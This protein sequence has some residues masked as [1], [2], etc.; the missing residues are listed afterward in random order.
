MNAALHRRPP[1]ILLFSTVLLCLR[2]SPAPSDDISVTIERGADEGQRALIAYDEA[3]QRLSTFVLRADGTR[4]LYQLGLWQQGQPGHLR[5]TWE[6]ATQ[7]LD[8]QITSNGSTEAWQILADQ[9]TPPAGEH[10]RR[11]APFRPSMLL[12]L[13]A[14]AD[15][16]NAAYLNDD[17]AA[18]CQTLAP[19]TAGMTRPTCR[20]LPASGILVCEGASPNLC[21]GDPQHTPA[22]LRCF[23]TEEGCGPQHCTTCCQPT[24]GCQKSCWGGCS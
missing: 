21:A 11:L 15:P 8:L 18:A 12:W 4:T 2:C 1:I 13:S 9:A 10:E 23:H 6:P 14:L 20:A 22:T 19:P 17:P 5:G 7:T 3:H 16:R 24:Y